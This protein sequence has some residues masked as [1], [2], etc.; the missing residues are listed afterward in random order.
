MAG[1]FA[2]NRNKGPQAVAVEPAPVERASH[3]AAFDTSAGVV[4][5]GAG[6][7]QFTRT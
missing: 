1:Y 3:L 5:V 7:R 2:K 4:S 6:E